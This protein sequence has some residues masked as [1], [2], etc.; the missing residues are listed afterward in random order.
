M[1]ATCKQARKPLTP[2][3][4]AS[5]AISAVLLAASVYAVVCIE[6][7]EKIDPETTAVESSPSAMF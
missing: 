5:H 7:A 3:T 6:R 4:L 1:S 2:A